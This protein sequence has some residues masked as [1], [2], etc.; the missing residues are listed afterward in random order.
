MVALHELADIHGDAPSTRVHPEIVRPHVASA[1]IGNAHV[2]L[3]RHAD[4]NHGERDANKLRKLQSSKQTSQHCKS[5]SLIRTFAA[6]QIKN[7]IVG[8]RVHRVE[9]HNDQDSHR[10]HGSTLD[11]D[12]NGLGTKILLSCRAPVQGPLD[13]QN[14]VGN[15]SFARDSPSVIVVHTMTEKS[16]LV[17]TILVAKVMTMTLVTHGFISVMKMSKPGVALMNFAHAP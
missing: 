3:E 13:A 1:A 6:Y 2:L 10:V 8:V 14:P 17:Q 7:G 4:D 15:Q 11:H 5:K 12:D 16:S 9:D